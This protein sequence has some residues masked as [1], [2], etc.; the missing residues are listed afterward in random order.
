MG[1][2]LQKVLLTLMLMLVLVTVC[3]TFLQFVSVHI[4]LLQLCWDRCFIFK[5]KQAFIYMISTT[6]IK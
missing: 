3:A 1:K 4:T 6:A 2:D 5:G